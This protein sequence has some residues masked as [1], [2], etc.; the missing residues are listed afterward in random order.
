MF[1]FSPVIR[2]NSLFLMFL[3]KDFDLASLPKSLTVIKQLLL[4][5]CNRDALDGIS[6]ISFIC[7]CVIM[8]V[9]FSSKIRLAFSISVHLSSRICSFLV[10]IIGYLNELGSLLSI[11]G[12]ISRIFCLCNLLLYDCHF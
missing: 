3:F 8:L 4:V 10:L 7:G 2:T 1:S 5:F 9:I 12:R 6:F 11:Y